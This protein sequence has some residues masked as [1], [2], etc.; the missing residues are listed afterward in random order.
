M[1]K[2]DLVTAAIILLISGAFLF[3]G[4]GNQEVTEENVLNL[5]EAE[6]VIIEE[7]EVVK[8]NLLINGDFSS[9]LEGWGLY[10]EQNGDS[11]FAENDAVGVLNINNSGSVDYSVQIYYDGFELY[12][13]GVYKVTLDIASTVPRKGTMRIQLNGGDYHA[14]VE[15]QFEIF[16]IL[17]TYEFEFSMD[18]ESDLVPRFCLNLGTP[19][20]EEEVGVHEI[21]VDNVKLE[22]LDA[23]DIVASEE[24]EGMPE[25]NLNQIGYLT[26]GEKKA[27]LRGEHLGETFQILDEEGNVVFEGELTGP[28]ENTTAAETNYY[29]DFTAF[30]EAGTYTMVSGDANSSY[31]F[32]IGDGIYEDIMKASIKMLYLQ[33]CGMELTEEYAGDFAHAACHL[34]E[35]TI[36]GTT[37][38]KDVSGGWHDAGDY[39]R[40]VSPGAITV[41]DLFLAYEDYREVFDGADADAYG[42][43]ESGNGIPDILDEARYELEW[44]LKMQDEAT[45]G[46]YHKVTCK[47]FPG[48]ILPEEETDELVLSPIST[49]ATGAFAA[50]MAKSSVVYKDLDAEFAM[51]CLEASE[52]AWTYLEANENTGG[53]TNPSDIV[54]GEYGDTEDADER[55]WAA[56]ELLNATGNQKYADF[57][58]SLLAENTYQGFGWADVGTYAS[59]ACIRLDSSMLAD[60]TLA[61]IK[62]AVVEEADALLT[63][64]KTDGYGISLGDDYMWG[65]NMAVCNYARQ[66]ILANEINANDEYIKAAT[67]HLHYILGTNPM[68][69]CYVTGFGTVSAMEPHHR[70][71]TVV[72]SPMPGMVIGGPDCG[73]HDPAAEQLLKDAPPAKCYVDNEQSYSTNEI[74]IYWNSPFIYLLGELMSK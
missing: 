42:I 50:I 45:G 9:G 40:Y 70:M 73:L 33:R 51:A 59:I 63:L 29:A 6:E 18:Y 38:T 54:T 43:P 60:T 2:L 8:E 71:S 34:E 56:A 74:T 16:D 22:L 3:A 72:G 11:T 19:K 48:F 32:V 53:F 62:A 27:V 14:Y 13:G 24:E 35:A 65:S 49:T 52:L 31:P 4:C 36:Y 1:K 47:T 30:T 64:S 15:E 39:G 26:D 23:S 25:I 20:D 57:I 46:V 5:E 55:Y 21:T 69:I 44:M 28:V 12:E 41:A 58:E 67:D 10:M 37:E 66:M 61:T 7:E 68:S 17:S